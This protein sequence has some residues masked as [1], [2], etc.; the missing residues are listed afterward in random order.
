MTLRLQAGGPANEYA[1]TTDASGYFTA[2]VSTLPNGNYFWRVKDP[3]YLAASGTVTLAGAPIAN[4]EMGL[5]KAGDADNNNVVNSPD[6][7]GDL[8]VNSGDFTLLKGN[9]G[10]AG[11]PPIGPTLAGR[12]F[13]K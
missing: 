2:P 11:A 12:G 6:F 4:A 3:K 5:Q 13:Q 8:V 10:I 9:F 7:N 1:G